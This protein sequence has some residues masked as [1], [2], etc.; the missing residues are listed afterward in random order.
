[1]AMSSAE[2]S[3]KSS[4]TCRASTLSGNC[5]LNVTTPCLNLLQKASLSF[6]S[7]LSCTWMYTMPSRLCEKVFSFFTSL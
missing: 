2:V 4:S 3:P 7:S 6:M 1:M 5:D